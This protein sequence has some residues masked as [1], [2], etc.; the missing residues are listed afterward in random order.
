MEKLSGLVSVELVGSFTKLAKKLGIDIGRYKPVRYENYPF[1]SIY[2]VDRTL[3]TAEKEWITKFE[4]LVFEADQIDELF[5]EFNINLA[6]HEKYLK[7]EQD[8]FNIV[9]FPVSED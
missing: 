8:S 9:K 7:L 4:I 5:D 2:C 6:L 3:S 1:F